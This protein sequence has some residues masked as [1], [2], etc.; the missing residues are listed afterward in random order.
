MNYIRPKKRPVVMDVA[1]EDKV[2]EKKRHKTH[3][4]YQ[5]LNV[6]I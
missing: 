1:V 2:R 3:E 5:Q 6:Y 4:N